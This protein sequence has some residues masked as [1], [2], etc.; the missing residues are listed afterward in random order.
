[1]GFFINEDLT[2]SRNKILLKARKMIKEKHLSSVWSSDGTILV[3]D[4]EGKNIEL[5]VKVTLPRLGQ[6][7]N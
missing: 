7:Q 6:Y 3:R 2:K 4:K 5:C 1:M